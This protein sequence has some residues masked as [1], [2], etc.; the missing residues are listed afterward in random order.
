MWTVRLIVPWRDWL[1]RGFNNPNAHHG[2]LWHMFD[3][4]GLPENQGGYVFRSD[5]SRGGPEFLVASQYEPKTEFSE[6]VESGIRADVNFIPDDVFAK[7]KQFRFVSRLSPQIRDQKTG[8]KRPMPQEDVPSWIKH[9]VRESSICACGVAAVEGAQV[10]RSRDGSV[11][12]NHVV[13]V[14]GALE[15]KDEKLFVKMLVEG[16]GRGKRFGLGMIVLDIMESVK[17]G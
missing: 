17:N 15:V 4:H 11:I 13:S 12:T 14:R 5:R 6:W 7:G 8:K 9:Q 1:R 2:F 16:I 3:H 10:C